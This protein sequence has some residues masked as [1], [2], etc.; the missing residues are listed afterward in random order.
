MLLAASMAT[1]LEIKSVEEICE[2]LDESVFYLF[3]ALNYGEHKK[4]YDWGGLADGLSE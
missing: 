1:A 2:W 3:T 4:D